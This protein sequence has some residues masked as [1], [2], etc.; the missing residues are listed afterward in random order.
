MTSGRL[1][2]QSDVPVLGTALT[3]AGGQFSS[4]PLEPAVKAYNLNIDIAGM[5]IVA[6]LNIRASGALVEVRALSQT[7]NGQPIYGDPTYVGGTL[8]GSELE[9]NI[10][11][12][13]DDGTPYF[14]H[15]V[16]SPFSFSL[17][18]VTGSVK[19]W[20]LNPLEYLGTGLVSMTAVN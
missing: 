2:I 17:S 9:I 11:S 15:F 16:M 1:E 7:H 20:N 19:M 12:S 13:A 14:Q 18:T 4:L 3:D 6:T 10:Y 5:S 8:V